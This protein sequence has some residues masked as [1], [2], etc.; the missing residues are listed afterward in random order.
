MVSKNAYIFRFGVHGEKLF[1][2]TPRLSEMRGILTLFFYIDPE[3]LLK[4]GFLHDF[5][6]KKGLLGEF[7]DIDP[8]MNLMPNINLKMLQVITLHVLWLRRFH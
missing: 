4:T 6:G 2:N 3:Q 7:F 8:I 1:Q 5:D